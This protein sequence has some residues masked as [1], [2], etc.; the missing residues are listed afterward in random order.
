MANKK[1]GGKG[2]KFYEKNQNGRKTKNYY[3]ESL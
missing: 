2:N 3:R 1:N